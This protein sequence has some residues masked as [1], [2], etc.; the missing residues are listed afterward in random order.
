MNHVPMLHECCRARG[1]A[2][3]E[4]IQLLEATGPHMRRAR[5]TGDTGRSSHAC[6]LAAA[7]TQ[8]RHGEKVGAVAG[9]KLDLE[10]GGGCAVVG[11]CSRRSVQSSECAVVGVCSRRRGM[12][13]EQRGGCARLEALL[14]DTR[15]R[16]LHVKVG[17]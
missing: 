5:R 4:M 13:A 14:G 10:K 6:T 16:A 9:Q 3:P 15:D 2:H 12:L 17:G 11:V 1:H 8:C 7:D